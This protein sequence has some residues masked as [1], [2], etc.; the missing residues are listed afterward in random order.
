MSTRA[1]GSQAS[2]NILQILPKIWI[3]GIIK[4][5]LKSGLLESSN[6]S[7]ASSSY[8]RVLVRI[9]KLLEFLSDIEH[10]SSWVSSYSSFSSFF[11]SW[12]PFKLLG[13]KKGYTFLK[14]KCNVYFHERIEIL[15]Q[16]MWWH[17]EDSYFI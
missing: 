16:K 3:V 13:L 11:S 6:S 8:I 7:G 10:L 15:L 12:P 5:Y 14:K 2:I 17:I 9:F 1:L 4:F